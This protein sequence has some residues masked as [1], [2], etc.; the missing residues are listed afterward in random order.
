MLEQLKM[1]SSLFCLT[2]LDSNTCNY[3][4]VEGGCVDEKT[5]EP[6]QELKIVDFRVIIS[7]C[8]TNNF[9]IIDKAPNFRQ[10]LA[11][12]QKF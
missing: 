1:L 4:I 5:G 11:K 6:V 9:I 10:I 2:D 7:A 8:S 3:G 12:V